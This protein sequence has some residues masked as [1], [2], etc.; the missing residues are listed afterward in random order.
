MVLA[1]CVCFIRHLNYGGIL[2]SDAE[3]YVVTESVTETILSSNS[4]EKEFKN[5]SPGVSE[6]SAVKMA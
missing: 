1:I 6:K 2:S 4:S 3:E 5:E